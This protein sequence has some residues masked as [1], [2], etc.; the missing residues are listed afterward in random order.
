ME[1]GHEGKVYWDHEFKCVRDI[2]PKSTQKTISHIP[3]PPMLLAL[4]QCKQHLQAS[5]QHL[6]F[7]SLFPSSLEKDTSDGE[8]AL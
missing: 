5:T 7:L 8:C 1:Q 4:V 3:H 2:L 6:S